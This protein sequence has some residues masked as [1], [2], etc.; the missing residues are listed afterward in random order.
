MA[1]KRLIP[2]PDP[3]AYRAVA[4]AAARYLKLQPW[5]AFGDEPIAVVLPGDAEPSFAVCMGAGGESFGVAVFRGLAGLRW[6]LEMNEAGDDQAE[7][8]DQLAVCLEA[9]SDLWPHDRAWGKEVGLKFG[10]GARRPM[11]VVKRPGY[12]AV[13][14]KGADLVRLAA[15]VTAILDA[16]EPGDLEPVG[17]YGA[18]LRTVVVGD[19]TSDGTSDGAAGS[20]PVRVETR[21]FE[22]PAR[23]PAPVVVPPA[24]LQNRT[25]GA[26]E[27]AIG[28]RTLPVSVDDDG[29]VAQGLLV[30]DLDSG[31]LLG[32]TVVP[33]GDPVAAADGVWDALNAQPAKEPLPRRIT[34][35][36]RACM[37]ST[38]EGLA[39][40]GIESEFARENPLLDE[41]FETLT[42]FLSGRG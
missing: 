8:A 26:G 2:C 16:V 39:A 30:A 7:E 1:T 20:P 37:E 32:N 33:A 15:T 10:R 29:R 21:E 28:L 9:A 19:G 18:R 36:S 4:A 17:E 23:E 25:V 13:A 42:G 6:L 27:W 22:P 31:L 38:R 11:T 35:T 40:L 3:A 41:A 12:A 14:P 24:E 5:D 34:F